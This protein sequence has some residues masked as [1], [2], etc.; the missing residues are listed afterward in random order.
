MKVVMIHGIAQEAFTEKE[1]LSTWSE[2]VDKAAP[3]LLHG[4]D[5]QM[6][7]YGKELDSWTTRGV[8]A[9]VDMG[10]KAGAFD[11][12]NTDELNFILRALEQTAAAHNVSDEAID[13]QIAV[14]G[15][16]K[17]AEGVAMG[18]WFGRRLV[19]L[20]R[21]LEAISPLKGALA[22]Q[23]IKQAYTYL[24]NDK[25]RKAVDDLVK[26]RLSGDKL[27]IVSHSLGTVV[28]FRL[29]REMAAAQKLPTIPLL[30]TLGSPLGLDAVKAKLGPPRLKPPLVQR[31]VN[32]YDPADFV[33]LG[34]YLDRDNFASG[35]ENVGDVNNTTS[36]AH[37]IIGYLPDTRVI[38]AL[39]SAL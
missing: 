24:A 39:K 18:T 31:W 19:G 13:E 34:K 29:L 22:L 5:V 10:I 36:N 9:A 30:I 27:V 16:V 15:S 21:A 26:P 38:Q 2:L 6:A 1:L 3:G 17:G 25:A 7:Y 20:V 12:T 8:S 32:F 4:A 28:A 33:A 11:P 23:V 37:G 14:A 35:I